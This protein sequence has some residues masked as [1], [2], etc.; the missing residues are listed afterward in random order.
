MTVSL[1]PVR[2]VATAMLLL[3]GAVQASAQNY[4]YARPWPPEPRYRLV[5]PAAVPFGRFRD[6]LPPWE[7]ET[8]LRSR[9]YTQISRPR[10]SG[11]VYRLHATDRRGWRVEL[12]VDSATGRI[13]EREAL[14]E[15]TGPRRGEPPAA[16]RSRPRQA[17]RPPIAPQSPEVE[18]QTSLPPPAARPPVASPPRSAPPTTAVPSLPPPNSPPPISVTPQPQAPAASA[19]SLPPPRSAAPSP[20]ASPAQGPAATVPAKADTPASGGSASAPANAKP[21]TAK[22]AATAKPVEA[23]PAPTKPAEKAKPTT[24]GTDSDRPIWAQ[25]R[26]AKPEA[27]PTPPPAPAKKPAPAISFPPVQGLE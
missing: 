2:I 27:A 5:P 7:I 22:P 18:P 11:P 24:P 25:R 3:G 6:E 1:G 4:Y 21:E 15:V 16:R 26:S 8:I 17:S 19:P 12:V 10:L 14:G 9:G 13:V 23:K 20:S